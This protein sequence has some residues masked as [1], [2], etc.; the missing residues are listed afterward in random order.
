MDS[1]KVAFLLCVFSRRLLLSASLLTMMPIA[2]WSQAGAGTAPDPSRNN[3]EWK[4]LGNSEK[5]SMPIGNGDLAANVW[6]EQNGDLVLL[7]AK[8]NAW[9]ELGKLDKLARIR[10]HLSNNP[11]ANASDFTQ[12]LHVE[13]ASIEITSGAN[14]LTIWTD[15]NRPALHVTGDLVHPSQVEASLELWRTQTHSYNE[16]SPDRGGLF[17][18]GEPGP[19]SHPIPIRFAADT[20]LPAAGNRLTWYHFNLDSIYPTVLV[21]QHLEQFKNKYPD[22]LLHRCFGATLEGA[23]MIAKDD[24]T[25]ASSRLEWKFSVSLVALTTNAPDTA[26]TWQTKLSVLDHSVDTVSLRQAWKEHVAWWTSFW[27]RSW[28]QL[29][30][31]E[32]A[33][34][35]EQGY[36]MQRY[37][38]AAS[39][40][41]PYPVKFNG[42]LFTVGGDVPD[43][44]D[45]TDAVHNPDYRRWGSSY[46]NQNN[47]HLYWPLLAT[48]DFDLVKPWFDMYLHA[49]PLAEDRTKA[50]YRHDGAIF[51]ETMDFWGLPNLNDFGW[52]NKTDLMESSY[53]R[54]HTQGSLDVVAQ[55]LDQYD[56]TQDENFARED[57]IP[58]AD[59]ILT[60]YAQ[61]W[62]TDDT[63]K[64]RFVPSQSIE[65][66]QMGATDPTPDIAGIYAAAHRLLQLPTR[67]TS[68]EQRRAWQQLLDRLPALPIGTTHDGKLPPFGKGDPDGKREILP[69]R[70]YGKTQNSENPE[71]YTV[72]PYRM[73]GVGKPEL[74]LARDTYAARLFP[75]NTCWGQ[76][77]EEAA[78]LGLTEDAQK[79]V[80]RELTNYGDQR[81][82]WF[83]NK[84]SDWIPDLDDGGAGMTT[85]QYMLLQPDGRR[86]LL[87]P[88]WPKGWTA[89][90]KL[91]APYQT[92]VEAHV[93]GGK[94]TSLK[95]T[96]E[97]RRKDVAF[98]QDNQ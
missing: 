70:V 3:V 14:H 19:K 50:Y 67:L 4:T 24:H 74:Q 98:L 27:N 12:T 65:T 28:I 20:I 86:I 62:N 22:P 47:R 23:G 33:R 58:L 53:M 79:D 17:G 46:W 37:M 9:S 10:I 95:V 40:R 59:A 83:W 25:L 54:Y 91:H 13:N 38:M 78:L 81:F 61:H 44:V 97:S 73:F 52:D 45:S 1:R 21:Q 93:E 69:A 88:A 11:F 96:P 82:K 15:A 57:L 55:M 7:I 42:G 94:V 2:C 71:L 8:S 80:T 84:A 34:E 90:F 64:I 29:S 92:I 32:D 76:D 72:F 48:G 75:F 26:E 30:G 5:D 36:A 66:Y 39:S 85:L 43:G 68:E 56:L 35:V 63:G 51:V 89:D 77:G 18:L 16:P 60:Y 41:G 87:L 31:N 6:T 49:L